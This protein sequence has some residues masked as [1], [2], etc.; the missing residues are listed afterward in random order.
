MAVRSLGLPSIDK[1]RLVIG[2]ELWQSSVRNE[3]EPD[4]ALSGECH[5]DHRRSL[6][7]E[8]LEAVLIYSP[9]PQRTI[10]RRCRRELLAAELSLDVV[11][12][13]S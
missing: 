3:G 5:R 6:R 13:I 12:H 10:A 2:H 8:E 11:E 7:C 9:L 4:V 1:F